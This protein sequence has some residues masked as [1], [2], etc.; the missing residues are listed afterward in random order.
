M[1]TIM[2]NAGAENGLFIQNESGKLRIEADCSLTRNENVFLGGFD[3]S[4]FNCPQGLLRYVLRTKKELVLNDAM[5]DETYRS[6]EYIKT[7]KVKS[8]LCYP[9][10]HK[11]KVI[12]ILYLENNLG[13]HAFTKNHLDTVHL[14][15]SQIAISLENS[16]LYQNLEHKVEDRTRKLNHAHKEIKDSI[17]YAKRIQTAILPQPSFLAEKFKKGFVL[18]KPKDVVSGDFFWFKEVDNILLF[19]AAD[20]T[21]HGVPGAMV[22]VVCNAALNRSVR[23]FSIVDPG[24]ILDKTKEL[25]I[26]VFEKSEEKVQDGMDISI[27][28]LNMDT[29]E[30]KWAGAN[31]SLYCIKEIRDDTP[32]SAL[33]NDTHFLHEI[34]PNVQPIGIY[35]KNQP[36]RTHTMQMDEG[37]MIFLYTDGYADQFGG[38]KGKKLKTKTFKK[39]LLDNFHRSP[40]DQKKVLDNEFEK[41]RG[42]EEQV[43]DVCV[44]GLKF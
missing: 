31:N 7:N 23:E 43:D 16:S 38:S 6:D 18:F 13:T 26:E 5:K 28:A 17:L 42:D 12:A 10:I 41:W 22:S 15:S 11:N 40:E 33:K 30:L 32:E 4:K 34:K 37:S 14:L 21:G 36:F 3:I 20:C 2:E 35:D 29:K 24:V 9:V 44:V 19:A 27:C 25:V 1:L 39:L 8:V